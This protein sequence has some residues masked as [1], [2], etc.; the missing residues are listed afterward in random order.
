MAPNFSDR[1]PPAGGHGEPHGKWFPESPGWLVGTLWEGGPPTYSFS[2][3]QQRLPVGTSLG[4]F[5]PQGFQI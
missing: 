1:L 3:W 4:Q 2:G 5:M